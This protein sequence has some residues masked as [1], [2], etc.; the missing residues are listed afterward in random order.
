MY[1]E[2]PRSLSRSMVSQFARRRFYR[3]CRL[4]PICHFEAVPAVAAAISFV[5][6]GPETNFCTLNY[7]SSASPSRLRFVSDWVSNLQPLASL[8]VATSTE[9]CRD[10]SCIS[11]LSCMSKSIASIDRYAINQIACLRSNK[12]HYIFAHGTKLKISI[13]RGINRK[14]VFFYLVIL[15][16]RWFNCSWYLHAARLLRISIGVTSYFLYSFLSGCT[17]NIVHVIYFILSFP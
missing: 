17:C 5:C 14:E 3:T 9:L 2:T 8:S 7:A 6:A 16:C 12:S 4:N 13:S 1:V 15:W 10:L 11:L